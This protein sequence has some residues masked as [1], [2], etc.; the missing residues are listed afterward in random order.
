MKALVY[1]GPSKKILEERP[2]PKIMAPTDAVVKMARTTNTPK[3]QYISEF[4]PTSAPVVM[5]RQETGASYHSE[6]R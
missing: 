4:P 2:D 5:T 3:Y 1:L 6:W